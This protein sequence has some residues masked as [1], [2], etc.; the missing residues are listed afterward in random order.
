MKVEVKFK[1]YPFLLKIILAIC[2]IMFCSMTVCAA[3]NTVDVISTVAG[4]GTSGY[5][6]NGDLAV[7]ALIGY[8]NSLAIGA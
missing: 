6:G 7:N 8:V 4:N 1:R 5:S 3:E 2:L